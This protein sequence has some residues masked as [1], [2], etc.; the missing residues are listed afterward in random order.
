MAFGQEHLPFLVDML[1]ADLP[2]E[3]PKL[4][5]NYKLIR[6]D[7]RTNEH[8]KGMAPPKLGSRIPSDNLHLLEQDPYLGFIKGEYVA[9]QFN[10]DIEIHVIPIHV[11]AQVLDVN[12]LSP[13][14]QQIPIDIGEEDPVWVSGLDLF[15]ILDA[16]RVCGYWHG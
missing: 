2:R 10:T 11:F 9:Y 1:S 5:R 6:R 14:P 4:L 3:I 12:L 16:G 8:D 15:K 7:G 13:L